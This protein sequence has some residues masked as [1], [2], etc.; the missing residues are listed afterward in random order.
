MDFKDP[1]FENLEKIK[2]RSFEEK[3]PDKEVNQQESAAI[4]P[5]S[6]TLREIL[7]RIQ[8]DVTRAL[9]ILHQQ[10]P[11]SE[12]LIHTPLPLPQNIDLSPLEESSGDANASIVE[13]IFDGTEMIGSDGKRYPVPPNYASKSKLVE[14]DG[15]K[16]TISLTGSLIYKQIH[17]LERDRKMGILQFDQ[18]TRLY[19]VKHDV[20]LW[21]VLTASVTYFK[22]VPGDE[23]VVLVPKEKDCTWAAVEHVIKKF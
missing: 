15:L 5:A 16:L 18:A 8:V 22:G 19:T 9:K 12:A 6:E 21:R 1:F 7:K 17:P 2:E 3:K 11:V 23:V 10:E 13:G 14:G 20:K 4:L